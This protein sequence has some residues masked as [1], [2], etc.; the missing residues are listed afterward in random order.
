MSRLPHAHLEDRSRT[1]LYLG[2]DAAAGTHPE[3]LR[4]TSPE[5]DFHYY[6]R[7]FYG[8]RWLLLAASLIGLAIAVV[9]TAR[10]PRLY[11]AQATVEFKSAVPPGKDLDIVKSDAVIP[12]ALAVR[13]LTTK[14]LAARVIKQA[15]ERGAEWF[16][17]PASGQHEAPS[18]VRA[19]W[20]RLRALPSTVVAAVRVT[21]GGAPPPTTGPAAPGP[22]QWDGVDLGT[23]GRYYGHI[24]IRPEP[25]TSLADIVVTHPDPMTSVAIANAHAE[26]FIDMDLETKVTSLSDAQSVVRQQLSETKQRLEA[27][28]K[29]LGEYQ[30]EHGILS[31]PK[32]NTT[33][34]R[35][36]LQQLNKLL[37]EAQGE[38]IVAEAAHRNAAGMTPDQLADTLPDPG[39][40]A[41]RD[42][43]LGLKAQYAARL[44]KYGRNHPDMAVLRARMQS[45]H[46]QLRAAGVQ[47]REQLKAAFEAAQAKE[48]GLRANF[49]RLSKQANVEDRGLVQ[50]LILQRDVETNQEIYSN[51]LQEA[52]EADLNSGVFRWTSV[53]LVD[54]AVV[55]DAPS[56]PRTG[57]NLQFG[58]LFGLLAGILACLLI[59]RLDTRIHTPEE[60]GAL[61]QLPTFGVVP[62]FWRLVPHN[63][64]GAP[65]LAEAAP[66]DGNR[67]LVTL[68]HPASVVSEAYR[69]IRTKLLF[70][71]PGSPPKTI[72]V[73]SSQA[74]EGKT[75]TVVNLAV[76]LAL[77]G[78]RVLIV[79][80]DLRKPSCHRQMRVTRD[81]GLSSVLTGQCDLATAVVLSPFF[82]N[83][84][85]KSHGTSAVYVL[86][87][88]A[89]PPNP[90]ELLGSGLMG[91]LLH[92]VKE[93][94]DFVLIDS[95]PI[96]P[97]TDSVV[98]ATKADGVL[99]VVKGGEWGRDIVQRALGHLDAV[100]SRVL[101][102]VL[103]C[104][105]VTRGGSPYYYYRYYY[106]G[107]YGRSG[108]E[109]PGADASD[110]KA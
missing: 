95:P 17:P 36:A 84:N 35:E 6:W 13:L 62:D 104:V 10:Q 100:H 19:A 46:D 8:R 33:I 45:L 29:A 37:T 18:L 76:S 64:T 108:A 26:T 47:A 96:L 99:L 102:V 105:D 67:E 86:P 61:L 7:V 59:E 28:R 83:G 110:L 42:E 34:T 81:P 43:L 70:S 27:S 30:S 97:V 39:L 92:A 48:R 66:R 3:A 101:G 2:S 11:Q 25:M 94:F 41:L 73:T 75:V 106:G 5:S 54:R 89:S 15:R 51:L 38:R 91:N 31:L 93:Q 88:G 87:A 82:A 52:K 65:E 57:R 16:G 58:L 44:D 78:S 90:A 49:E 55:P 12:P 72:L 80:A 71:S 60:V 107:Y 74:G 56:F 23:I 1:P 63:G 4:R 50:L 24:T 32:D 109:Q 69:G 40:K 77:S 98:M 103:N 14:V 85:G 22:T 21:L 20:A 68:M 53:K 79:D 9:Y